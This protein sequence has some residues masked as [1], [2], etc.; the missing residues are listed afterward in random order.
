MA[1]QG[2]IQKNEHGVNVLVQ[3]EGSGNRHY[4]HGN[5]QVKVLKTLTNEEIIEAFNKESIG[6]QDILIK[7]YKDFLKKIDGYA[8]SNVSNSRNG[9][10][11]MEFSVEY[12]SIVAYEELENDGK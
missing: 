6:N 9:D 12:Q 3:V 11:E 4:W 1:L 2:K 10:C 8:T 5:K 7:I